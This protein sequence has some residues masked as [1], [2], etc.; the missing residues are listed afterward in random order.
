M[1]FT[2]KDVAKILKNHA[3]V[4]EVIGA[5]RFRTRAYEQAG[6]SIEN[7]S[8]EVFHVWKEGNVED[9]PGVGK[10]I[11]EHLEE[12]FT[13]GKVNDFKKAAEKVPAGMY[14][15]LQIPGV[16]P[17]R[18]FRLSKEL[19]VKTVEDLKEA[20]FA[21][22]VA[23]LEGFGEKS[24][25]ELKDSIKEWENLSD[26]FLLER[27]LPIAEE[28]LN[29]LKK[30]D[31]V[32]KAEALGSLRRFVPTVGDI[33]LAV[34][35]IKPKEVLDL[36]NSYAQVAE[37]VNRGDIKS[38]VILKNNMQV[39]I[40]TTHPKNWGALLQHFTG[41]KEHN[42]RLRILSKEAGWTLSEK[43]NFETE[44]E[45]YKKLNMQYIPPEIRENT[46]EI[47][48]ALGG[49]LPILIELSDIKGDL[50]MHTTYS[51]GINSVE[52]I[53]AAA[54]NKMY[55]YICITDHAPSLNTN[56]P[57]QIRDWIENRKRD[58][59]KAQ[60]KY[61]KLQ[62]I[63]GVEVNIPVSGGLALPD[64][65]LKEFDWVLASVHS[66]FRKNR[67]EQ[68]KRIIWAISNPYVNVLAH[69]TGRILLERQGIETAWA[70]VFKEMAKFGK[71]AEINA[72]PQRLDLYDE[73]IREAKDFGVKFSISTDAHTTDQLDNMRYG[74]YMARRGWLTKKDVVNTLGFEEFKYRHLK[75]KV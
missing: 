15:L 70:E 75:G 26:R 30:S 69:P 35:T 4:L 18:A 72:H 37:V 21:N 29:Y 20:I 44:E 3:A 49:K 51:D 11:A 16:G 46:G 38:T 19:N 39:D 61:P 71:V 55:Q 57:E 9:V 68:T 27:A 1:L 66:G 14:E 10:S 2:N 17:K 64:A 54:A 65:L 36:F 74:V 24:Q 48:L 63:N 23:S 7:M 28:Y 40:M 47:E 41:S 12:L 8:E 60:L 62:V 22:K 42:V 13:K 59:K 53:V 25:Q 56:S 43:A 32:L 50:Q 73:L 58:F 52:E 33:D 6:E 5:D 34:A 45:L 67:D 31:A